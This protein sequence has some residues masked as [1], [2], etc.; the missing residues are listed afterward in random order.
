MQESTIMGRTIE[1]IFYLALSEY[2]FNWLDKTF[3]NKI[4]QIR[5]MNC[6]DSIYEVFFKEKYKI[7]QKNDIKVIDY[8]ENLPVAEMPLME[9]KKFTQEE[10]T[11]YLNKIFRKL[12]DN[13]DKRNKKAVEL[14]EE[15]K[16]SENGIIPFEKLRQ[17]NVFKA[18]LFTRPPEEI[19][20]G[21]SVLVMMMAIWGI[22]KGDIFGNNVDKLL[23]I[24]EVYTCFAKNVIG[25][26][27]HKIFKKLNELLGTNYEFKFD[28][29]KYKP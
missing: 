2:P 6:I 11:E 21:T 29:E 23:K 5:K 7:L 10:F 13:F 22:K 24:A 3:Q 28:C 12:K 20:K 9:G 14:F 26:D 16:I 27:P 18:L 19:R 15:L 1:R 8:L 17:A 4:S 25:I